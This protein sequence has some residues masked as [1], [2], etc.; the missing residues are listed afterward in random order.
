MSA[1]EILL[2]PPILENICENLELKDVISLQ[3]S[4]GVNVFHC[5]MSV[6]DP[7]SQ[8]TVVFPQIEAKTVPIY[9]SVRQIGLT[10]TY[11][12][13]VK[14]NEI[15]LVLYLLRLG[16]SIETT[17]IKKSTALL[18]AAERGYNKLVT[19][20]L[21]KGANV[22]ATNNFENAPLI[23]ATNNNHLQ[24]AQILL[25]AGAKV[26]AIGQDGKTALMFPCSEGFEEIVKILL[27]HK[28]NPNIVTSSRISALMA[29]CSKGFKQIVQLLINYGANVN[30]IGTNNIP[31]LKMAAQEN[32]PEIVLIL[33]KAGA[34]VDST[35]NIISPL[36]LASHFGNKQIVLTLLEAG[37][38][39]NINLGNPAGDTPLSAAL[40]ERLEETIDKQK[41]KG[42][43]ALILLKAGADPSIPRQQR[44]TILKKAIERGYFQ[45]VNFLVENGY[46]F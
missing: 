28:A 22:N 40:V 45:V 23:M 27:E 34:N 29:A 16:V 11:I 38:N 42:E 17:N 1:K 35:P 19:I 3:K 36:I 10:E 46:N 7:V 2:D 43:I 31:A 8:K 24:T 9:L 30:L 37:A 39:V 15:N 5:P 21:E 4:L 12:N 18:L 33:L 20:L 25:E 32:F 44:I 6:I 26:N 13:A 14:N 41:E